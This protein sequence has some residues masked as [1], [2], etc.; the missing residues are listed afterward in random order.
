MGPI[1]RAFCI[2]AAVFAAG[3][4]AGCDSLESFTLWDNKKPIPG[5]RKP[6]FPGGVPGVAQGIPQELMPGYKT[7]EGV[8]AAGQAAAAAAKEAEP[9]PKPA[10]KRVARPNPPAAP[11]QAAASPPPSGAGAQAPSAQQ[12]QS[13][14]APWPTAPSPGSFQR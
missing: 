3:T 9:K 11:R 2:V 10:P 4:V 5:E 13:D 6:V 7:P 8:D 12:A 1:S 14:Q